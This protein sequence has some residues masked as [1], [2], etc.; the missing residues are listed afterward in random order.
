LDIPQIHQHFLNSSGICTDTRK[1]EPNCMFFALKGDNFNGNEFAARALEQGAKFAV[2]D[3]PSFYLEDNQTMLCQD[4][5][6]TLQALANY[7]RKY[8]GIPI[9]S[10]TGSNGKTTTKE[11]IQAV[12]SQKYNCVATQGN[13]NNHIG[14][15][16][17]LLSMNA[18]TELGIVEMGA[19]HIGEIA[20]LCEIAEP[21]YG[22]ITN[23]GKAH[24]EGFGGIEGVIQGK[25]ELYAFL[26][27]HHGIVFVNGAD[28]TQNTLTQEMDRIVFNEIGQDPEIK[29]LPGHEFVRA[30]YDNQII[31]SQLIGTYNFTNIAAA[32]AFGA[33]FE[34]PSKD[35]ARA[36]SNYHPQMNRSQLLELRGHKIIMDAYNANPSSMMVALENFEHMAGT[37]KVMIL[38]DMFELG[39]DAPTEHQNIVK[40]LI[41]HAF[42]TVFLVGKNFYN[43]TGTGPHIIKFES[44]DDLRAYLGEKPL[45]ASQI[46]IKGSRGMA[47]ERT[48]DLL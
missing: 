36:I 38:G 35:I 12:L 13:L 6:Q 16:L 20:A 17:T 47:L 33:H 45:L 3:E 22:Y 11:L 44:F 19:N 29:Y 21:N 26:R 42:G 48:L 34:V 31:D 39:K 2:I 9:I 18:S 14:V 25:S 23:F 46:L 24:L 37:S 41:H 10:L 40:H 28:A 32:I 30:S 5:L 43:T 1:I 7:H 15:P 27:K 8:L 4:S